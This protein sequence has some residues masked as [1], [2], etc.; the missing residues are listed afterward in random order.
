MFGFSREQLLQMSIEKLIA[1]HPPY[2]FTEALQLIEKSMK[3]GTQAFEWLCKRGNGEVF[4]TEIA[5]TP[6]SEVKGGRVLAVIRDISDRKE[7]EKMRE[8]MLSNISHEMRTPLTAM[9]GFLEFVIENPVGETEL[10][11]YHTIMHREA[12]RLNEM[13]TNFL[14]MQRLKAKLSG[15]HFK[16]VDLRT[17]IEGVVALFAGPAALHS[18]VVGVPA[19][20]P[21]VL[22]DAELLHQAIVNLLSNA[23]KYSP[24]GSEITL[25]ARLEGKRAILSVKDRGIGIPRESLEKVF[26]MFYRV[27][28]TSKHHATGTGLGLALVKEIAETHKGQVWAESTLGQGSTFYISLPVVGN[29]QQ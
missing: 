11:E 29:D 15:N 1:G 27:Q 25:D 9:L 4:W 13:I 21:P 3:E 10:R 19:T 2:S 20:L 5:I 28:I 26:D 14:D 12:E 17:L 6:T 16:P 7:I 23:V 24:Q 8:A 22:G 18:F